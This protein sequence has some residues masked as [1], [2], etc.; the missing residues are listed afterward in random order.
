MQAPFLDCGDRGGHFGEN[1]DR[2]F[3]IVDAKHGFKFLT[4]REYPKIVLIESFV[5]NQEITLKF[6]SEEEN[7]EANMW[8]IIVNLNDV[9]NRNEIHRAV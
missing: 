1:S 5:C 4:A 6:P 8:S 2:A 9:V 7:T 3:L